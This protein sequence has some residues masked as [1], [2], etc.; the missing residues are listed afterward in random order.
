M[1]LINKINNLSQSKFIE[2]FAN[3]FENA[4]WIAEDVYSKKP[5]KDFANLFQ[6]M[7]NIF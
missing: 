4:S 1:I 3:I 7:L 6:K 2:I 5:F